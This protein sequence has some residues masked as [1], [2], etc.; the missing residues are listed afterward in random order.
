[1]SVGHYFNRLGLR[2]DAAWGAR[3]FDEREFAEIAARALREDHPADHVTIDDVIDW[4]FGEGR[5]VRQRA[6]AKDV[7]GQ[8]PFTVFQSGRFYIEVLLWVDGSTSIHE[9][10][11][12]GAFT[13]ILGKSV[14]SSWS[15]EETGRR[16]S[17][18]RFGST[19]CESLEILRCGDVREIHGGSR[20]AHQLFHLDRPSATVVVRTHGDVE[21]L[22]Q[23]SYFPPGLAFADADNEDPY[24]TRISKYLGAM[25]IT[26]DSRYLEYV[27]RVMLGDDLTSCFRCLRHISSAGSG[28]EIAFVDGLAAEARERHG[29]IYDAI[30]DAQ[31]FIRRTSFIMRRR[32][33]VEDETQRFVLAMLMLMPGR[34]DILS[35][36]AAW[37]GSNDAIEHTVAGLVRLSGQDLLGVQLDDANASIVRAI[38]AT[39][40]R[41]AFFAALESE[42]G[43]DQVRHQ[44]QSIETQARALE[45]SILIQPLFSH[46]KW[47]RADCR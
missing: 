36:I 13:P 21:Y 26:R 25:R 3:S 20:G 40:T 46:A 4:A 8:P 33:Q 43:S 2:I 41:T 22:P 31:R 5:T 39:E 1:M 45:D 29:A 9:H 30:Q 24:W 37:T 35:G 32:R 34:D 16:T 10:G 12:T 11:F 15:F 18:L 47:L 14:H 42:Y 23:L 17:Q 38:L 19:R 28:A 7:F 27:R 44:E 6:P